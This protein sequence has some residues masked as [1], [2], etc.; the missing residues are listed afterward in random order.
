MIC[1]SK[2][3]ILTAF[4]RPA[5]W[6]YGPDATWPDNGEIDIIEHVNQEQYDNT[7]LHTSNGCAINGDGT[8]TLVSKTCDSPG[9]DGSNTGCSIHLT[10]TQTFGVGFNNNNGGVYAMEWTSSA[11]SIWMFPRGSIP[12]SVYSSSPDTSTFGEA[13]AVFSGSCDIASKFQKQKIVINTTFCG[14]WAGSIWS[15]GSCASL[16]STCSDYVQNNPSAFEDAY[17]TINNLTVFSA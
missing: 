15:S 10:N 3:L 2:F 4:H 16:A 11:I 13:R 1:F 9:S 8:G 6:T 14:D 12:A 5:F 7:A 17:W